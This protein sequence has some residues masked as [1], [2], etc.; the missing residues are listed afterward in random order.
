MTRITLSFDNGPDAEV[1]PRILDILAQRRLHAWFFVVGEKVATPAGRAVLERALR[2][3]HRIGN[4]SYTHAVPL[5][6][7][8]RPDAVAR[9]IVATECLLDPLPRVFRPFGGGGVLGPHLLSPA[10]VHYLRA[11]DYAVVLWNSVPHDWDDP[12]WPAR[13]SADCHHH[14]HTLVVLHDLPGACLARL[15]EWLD[16]MAGAEFTL[17]LPADCL[18]SDLTPFTRWPA[19]APV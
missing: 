4:H 12:D 8:P 11:R 2:E 18:P 16:T 6:D 9:E 7:D 15:T 5:G 10:A 13:A 17:D 3:G 19:Q 1:T 14:P